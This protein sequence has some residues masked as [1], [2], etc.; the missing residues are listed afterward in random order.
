MTPGADAGADAA[1]PEPGG[2]A[3]PVPDAEPAAGPEPAAVAGPGWRRVHPVTPVLRSWRV[4]AVFLVLAVNQGGDNLARGDLPEVGA[5]GVQAGWAA[6]GL[7]AVLLALALIGALSYLSWR[8]TRFRVDG[9]ALEIY[10][11]V[12][13][14]QHRRA[15]LDRIQTVDVA[16]P[17]VARL[18]GL[19]RLTVEVAGGSGSKISLSYLSEDDAT[20]LRAQLLARAAGVRYQGDEAPQ[21]PESPVLEVPVARL[22]ASLLLS[23]S[24]VLLVLLLA[25]LTTTAVLS[26][27]VGSV[28]GF[29]PVLLGAMGVLWARF[30]GG[31]GFRVG[32]SPDGLRL[33]HGLL[34]Q[35]AQTVP[36]GR[37]QAVRIRQTL[38]W[39]AAGWWS[40]QVNVAGYAGDGGQ[41]AAA[42]TTL[43]PVGTRAEV[44]QVLALVLPDLGVEPDERP[45]EVVSAGLT[46]S[47]PELGYI[48]APPR[49][50]RLDP[51]GYRRIGVR[52]TGHAVLLRAGVLF[53]TL[54][55]VLHART[56]SLSLAQGPFQK[57]LR[58]ATFVLHST[59]GPVKPRV[60]HLDAA[61]AAR[62]LAD[63]AARARAA[64]SAAGS[65][66]WMEQPRP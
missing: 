29:V 17:L 11:G 19:A 59:P 42:E 55:V 62:L 5:G 35:R 40:I 48:V 2:Q 25:G 12:L 33:R 47:E 26:G 10:S 30:N 37:V 3:D 50:R 39:R 7:L 36:P 20:R 65:E 31:F 15:R 4:I 61:V 64:R 6:L 60:K 9:D 57:R 23:A 58:V 43:L 49:S 32:T 8:F 54:D 16:Q 41:Q 53:R 18:V 28:A 52:I 21:A 1:G 27:S 51:I 44:M 66:R 34:E 22:V 56:Q 38:L 13:F 14:R 46:S 24:T 63:Q 45:E